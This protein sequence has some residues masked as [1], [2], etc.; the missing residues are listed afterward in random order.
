MCAA[1][2]RQEAAYTTKKAR[3]WDTAKENA[4]ERL[5]ALLESLGVRRID[6]EL[7]HPTLCDNPPKVVLA[8]GVDV[9]K[10]VGTKYNDLVKVDVS[11]WGESVKEWV[12]QGKDLPP[13]IEVKSVGTHVKV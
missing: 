1:A 12:A 10:L 9:S 3:A 2:L 13:G 7:C 11:L 4:R 5:K 8:E 6:T